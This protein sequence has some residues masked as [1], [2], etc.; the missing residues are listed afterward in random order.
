MQLDIS[1]AAAVLSIM[2]T[3]SLVLGLQCSALSCLAYAT[4][5]TLLSVFAN[6]PVAAVPRVPN[7][8]PTMTAVPQDS[9]EKAAG[10]PV[11]ACIPWNENDIDLLLVLAEVFK[12]GSA[13]RGISCNGTFYVLE[14]PEARVVR[15]PRHGVHRPG[16][17]GH[18]A[19]LAFE[20]EME[21]KAR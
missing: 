1:R 14:R 8:A 3:R 20:L 19:V 7:A 9:R 18:A 6:L 15:S 12:F 16:V 17:V 4:Q 2:S 21:C 10:L 11:T 5:Y 13:G